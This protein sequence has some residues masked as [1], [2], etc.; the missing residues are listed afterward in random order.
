MRSKVAYPVESQSM[1]DILGNPDSL[2]ETGW[3]PESQSVVS[4]D[5]FVLAGMCAQDTEMSN[6]SGDMDRVVGH[7]QS[8]GLGLLFII[9]FIACP[10]TLFAIGGRCKSTT[11]NTTSRRHTWGQLDCGDLWTIAAICSCNLHFQNISLK[12]MKSLNNRGWTSH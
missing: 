8:G 3:Q 7:F 6:T 2:G 10:Q 9:V 5:K 11:I 4:L 1:F 12:L